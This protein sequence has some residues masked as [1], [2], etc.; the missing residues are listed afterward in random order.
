MA[1][2]DSQ[3]AAAFVRRYQA[4]VFGLAL[5]IVGVPATAEEV[6]QEAFLRAWRYAGGYDPRR[7]AVASWL[8]TIT[9]N[10]AIDVVRVSHERPYEPDTLLGLLD[11]Q[12]E[13]PLE[14]WPDADRVRTALHGLPHEQAVAVVLA[15]FYGLTAREIAEREDIPLGTAKTRIRL[16]LIRLRDQLEVTD[17]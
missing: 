9:R 10:A 16:G 6:A 11:P 12:A 3:A 4:R 13:R 1:A 5:T 2:G 17:D 8:L 7:G 15:T 14:G